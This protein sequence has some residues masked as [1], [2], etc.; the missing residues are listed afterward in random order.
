MDIEKIKSLI[1]FDVYERRPGKYQ[2]IVPMHHEDGDMVDVYLQDSP[3]ELGAIRVCDFGMALMRLSYT[4]ELSFDSR[5]RFLNSILVN[6]GVQNDDGNLFI[7]TPLTGLHES[8][9]RFT[10]CVQKVCRF[11]EN[12]NIRF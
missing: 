8:I 4:D 9:L 5:K 1:G 11:R 10:S 2:L 6:D 12:A 7:D 3:G